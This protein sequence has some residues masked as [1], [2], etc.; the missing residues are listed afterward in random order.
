TVALLLLVTASTSIS[1]QKMA[2]GFVNTKDSSKSIP[3][4]YGS[5]SG[6]SEGLA[7]VKKGGKWGYID[8]NNKAVIDFQFDYARRFKQGRAIVQKGDCYGVINKEGK[9]V[10]P[11]YYYDLISYEL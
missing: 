5:A 4:V 8:V 2:H 3:P 9:F 1:A 7:A 10:I 6:F 11:P